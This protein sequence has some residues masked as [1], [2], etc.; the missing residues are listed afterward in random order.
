LLKDGNWGSSNTMLEGKAKYKELNDNTIQWLV[1]VGYTPNDLVD[2]NIINVYK[3]YKDWSLM[4][5]YHPYPINA[6]KE[7]ICAML[8]LK[9]VT[10]KGV[11][12]WATI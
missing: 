7:S 2:T 1:E 5:E 11:S 3:D 6:F 8:K 10:T 4:N 9:V 12:K